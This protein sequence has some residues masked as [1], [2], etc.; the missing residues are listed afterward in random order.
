M[1]VTMF[2]QEKYIPMCLCG[3]RDAVYIGYDGSNFV[4]HNGHAHMETHQGAQTGWYKSASKKAL[5]FTQPSVMAGIQVYLYGAAVVPTSYE[6]EFIPE[7]AAIYTTLTFR[8]GM[9]IRISA[10]LTYGDCIWGEKVEILEMPDGIE[11]EIGFRVNA[12]FLSERLKF[13]RDVSCEFSEGEKNSLKF[14]FITGEH[15]GK[16][17]LI[18][19]RAFDK[20]KIST[21]E[22]IDQCYAEGLYT[23]LR[24]G[25]VISRTMICLGDN[26]KHIGYEELREKA[27]LGFDKLFHEHKKLW[28]EYYATCSLSLENEELDYVF[29][30]S[31]Y[32]AK[33]C[34]GEDSGIVTLGMLPYHWRGAASCAW[35]EEMVHEAMLVTGNLKESEHFTRQ[36]QRQ[37]PEGYRILKEKGLPGVAFTGWNSLLGEF[38][39]HRPIDEWLT[40]FK[41]MFAIYGVIAIYNEWKYNPFFN[42]EEYRTIAVDVLKFLL[43]GLVRKA[44]DGMYYLSDVRDGNETGVMASVDTSTTLKFAE[45]FLAVGEMYGIDEYTEIGESMLKTL[46]GNK[47]ADGVIMAARNS[48]YTSSVCE[49]YKRFYKRLSLDI[50]ALRICL[51][52]MKTP[53][54]YDSQIATEEKRHWPWYDG[55]SIR[56]FVVARQ[57]KSAAEHLK[58]SCYGRSSLGALPEFIRLDGVGIGYYYTTP[59]GLY[60]TALCDAVATR[61]V[62]GILLI[63]YGLSGELNCAHARDIVVTGGLRVSLD[64]KDGKLLGLKVFNPTASEVTLGIEINPEI[65]AGISDSE[66]T[67]GAGESYRF[68]I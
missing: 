28:E 34:Q 9:K 15:R 25:D 7:E 36:Y 8:A 10:F 41:P 68:G 42:A 12:P 57:P 37:A 65:S 32:L 26:E 59:H 38:C 49:Y 27:A 51:S 46:E 19:Q 13:I 61:D 21:S 44:E 5:E 17:E 29:K 67:V 60:I 22:F 4:S 18:A 53:F 45:G 52:G 47:R 24:A 62:D 23:G 1:K 35:D 31:R 50:S 33:A 56:D 14:S 16:G 20:T 30:V 2:S 48:P 3:G 43:S 63:G 58:H 6:Q 39:G 66:I 64:I 11:P 40:T 54:G 55:W